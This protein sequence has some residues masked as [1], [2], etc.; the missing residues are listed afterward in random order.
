[1]PCE[2]LSCTVCWRAGQH[3]LL[4]FPTIVTQQWHL[5]F[6]YCMDWPVGGFRF[7]FWYAFAACWWSTQRHKGTPRVL[8]SCHQQSSA[9]GASKLEVR[10][11]VWVQKEF[12]WYRKAGTTDIEDF[13]SRKSNP[14][15]QNQLCWSIEDTQNTRRPCMSNTNLIC[16]SRS[17]QLTLNRRQQIWSITHK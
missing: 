15:H 3:N 1:M 7:E 17:F 8:F 12:W 11:R 16:A 4:E 2:S 6:V 10:Q 5:S 9:S 13:G 14:A